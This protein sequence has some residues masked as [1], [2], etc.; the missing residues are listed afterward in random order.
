MATVEATR[1]EEY[2]Q[3]H[4]HTWASLGA[5]DDGSAV[6]IPGAAD[7][8]VHVT[9][10]FDGTSVTLEGSNVPTP[11]ADADWFTLTD[12]QGDALTFAA[13]GGN[14]V[15]ENTLWIRPHG[16]GGGGSTDVTVRVLSR[17]T[18]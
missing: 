10:T 17:W 7:K 18:R 3:T 8:S 11:S 14:I 9:G 16:S 13:A 5:D 12:P 1:S 4:L 6:P 2:G 15:I